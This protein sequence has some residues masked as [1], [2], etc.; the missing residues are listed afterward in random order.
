MKKIVSL[1]GI[2]IL[3]I[4]IL[5][6]SFPVRAAVSITGATGGSAI[7]A[8][9]C[10]ATPWTTLTGPVIIEGSAADISTGTIVL[11]APSGFEFN[12]AQNVTA[13]VSP[14]NIT[15]SAGTATP[16]ASAVTFTVS[17]TSNVASTITFS[18]VQVRP[19]TGN[20]TI[21]NTGNLVFSGTAGV[22]GNAGTLTMVAGTLNNFLVAITPTSALTGQNLA[23]TITARDQHNNTTTTGFSG[24]VA[25][26]A[27]VGG[28]LVYPATITNA[29]FTSGV[30]SGNLRIDKAGSQTVTATGNTK[31]GTD[32][33]TITANSV[34]T[35]LCEASGQAGAIWLRWTEPAQAVSGMFG[36]FVAKHYAAALTD[37][38]WASGTV[39]T[40]T[41]SPASAQGGSNQQLIIGLNPGTR[42]YFGLTLGS[43]ADT[44]AS[45]VSNSPSCIAPSAAIS[46]ADTIA[47][48][49]HITLPA[50]QSTVL[51]G[52]A[53]MIKGTVLDTGGSSAQKVEVSVDGAK[54]WSLAKATA[55][56]DG[57]LVWEFTWQNPTVG[58]YTIKTRAYDWA[59]NVEVPG[60]GIQITVAT[61]LPSAEK[62]VSQMTA[63]E[64]EAKIVEI[65]QK[66]VEILSQMI[67]LIQQRIQQLS[68]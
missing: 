32:T 57:N 44:I 68:R 15:L 36:G 67:Q 27:S 31:T 47:P 54:T 34:S 60:A 6:W 14:G 33:I 18:D 22:S 65:Q 19:K 7:S 8:D 30:W 64:L 9:T 48:V 55:N 53:L 5:S 46:K 1:I 66:I 52:Q 28:T 29:S 10:N 49:S 43:G 23:T 11:T 4:G 63:K 59:G 61:S 26:T 58:A 16:S 62:P 39:I 3:T 51:A 40:Q 21:P 24:N 13:A 41:W 56:I 20:C 38:N 35:L 25:M 50:A 2:L 45:L 37:G 17:A 12:T 42:Y